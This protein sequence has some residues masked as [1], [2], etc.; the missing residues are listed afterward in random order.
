P[1]SNANGTAT[2]T[3]TV[4]DGQSQN[5]TV[6]RTF[7]VTVNPVNDPPTLA[8]IND[9]AINEDAGPQIVGL[10]GITSGAGN[11]NQKLNLSASSSNPAMSPNHVVTYTNPDSAGTLTFT[12]IPNANG[13]ATI[14]VTVTDGQSE[15][16]LVTRTFTVTVRSVNDPLTLNP[17]T[18]LTIS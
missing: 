9:L 17:I 13:A 5:N 6:S 1:V 3:V 16:S 4:N 2:I 15:N 14:T 18:S 8:P 7:T 10:F 12:P 11:E